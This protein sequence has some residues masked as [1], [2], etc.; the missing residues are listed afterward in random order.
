VF[1]STPVTTISGDE[2]VL[3]QCCDYQ[4]TNLQRGR[5]GRTFPSANGTI[6]AAFVSRGSAA[7]AP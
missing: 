3:Q 7:A 6:G 5:A 2:I 1:R 4:G